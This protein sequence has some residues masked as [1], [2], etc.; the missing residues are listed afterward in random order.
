[1]AAERRDRP[2][3]RDRLGRRRG[4]MSTAGRL[5]HRELSGHRCRV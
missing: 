1:V 2:A 3:H 5:E 4:V